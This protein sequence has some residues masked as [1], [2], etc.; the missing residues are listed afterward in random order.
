MLTFAIKTVLRCDLHL[1]SNPIDM[2]RDVTAPEP[3]SSRNKMEAHSL[4][5]V[6]CLLHCATLRV[7][8]L[9]L[10]LFKVSAECR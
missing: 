9:L 8:L 3:E 5:S 2:R 7:S 4:C 6:D 10:L 1:D